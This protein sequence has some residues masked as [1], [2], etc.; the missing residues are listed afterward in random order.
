MGNCMIYLIIVKLLRLAPTKLARPE[1]LEITK[2]HLYIQMITQQPFFT[3]RKYTRFCKLSIHLY[4][5]LYRTV[6]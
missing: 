3:T 4:K 1:E 6:S 5:N 2:K